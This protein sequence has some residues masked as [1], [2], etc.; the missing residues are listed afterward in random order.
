MI[1]N[2]VGGG[3][4]MLQFECMPNR[5]SFLKGSVGLAFGFSTLA[6]APGA[7]AAPENAWIVGPQPGFTPEI[8]TLTSMLDFTRRQVL[9]N[10]KGLSQQDLDFL[11]D[12]KAN[13]IGALLLHLAATE[14]YYQMNTF[15]GMKWDSWSEEVKKK[16]DIPMNLGE[17]ARKAIKG[18]SP[19]YYLDALHQIREKS[20]AEFRKR[21]DKWLATVVTEEDFSANNYAKWFHVAEH[22]S[23]HDGQIKFLKRRIPGA[24]ETSE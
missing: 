9:N 5:R 4:F 15:D 2:Q 19:D 22:E 20:L 14:T 7:L 17:P 8:G 23:N 24:K 21:D 12:A 10:V 11:L 13:T 16:W 6:F 3:Q 1:R 18:N